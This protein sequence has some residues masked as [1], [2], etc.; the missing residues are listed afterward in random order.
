[1]QKMNRY[2]CHGKHVVGP[3]NSGW[4]PQAGSKIGSAEKGFMTTSFA[5]RKMTI[6]IVA[7]EMNYL[8]DKWP[9][10]EYCTPRS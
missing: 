5:V 9:N 6:S 4:I 2:R 10:M 1:M 3:F 7:L 8:F